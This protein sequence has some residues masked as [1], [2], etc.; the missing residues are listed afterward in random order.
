L[1]DLRDIAAW[2]RRHFGAQQAARYG[3]LLRSAIRS[4]E[5]GP[6]RLGSVS[7]EETAPGLRTLHIAQGRRRGR[8]LLAYRAEKHGLIVIHRILHDAMDLRRHLSDQ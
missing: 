7:R 2:T 1:R 3:E 8:H 5:D 6:D 4:L